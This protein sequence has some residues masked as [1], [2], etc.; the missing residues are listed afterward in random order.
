[1]PGGSETDQRRDR[2]ERGAQR[3]RTAE[4]AE[5]AEEGPGS[6]RWISSRQSARPATPRALVGAASIVSWPVS[7]ASVAF[8]AF[9]IATAVTVI[10][11]RPASAEV[12]R[13]RRVPASSLHVAPVGR[14]VARRSTSSPS[15]SAVVASSSIVISRRTRALC[16]LVGSSRAV[17]WF[18][19]ARSPSQSSQRLALPGQRISCVESPSCGGAGWQPAGGGEGVS[20]T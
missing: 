9:F 4:V 18:H 10:V 8:V 17:A 11:W 16:G 2:R 20:A 19:D 14:P 5:N 7:V 1:M 3:G 12:G 6:R 13:Q 15:G